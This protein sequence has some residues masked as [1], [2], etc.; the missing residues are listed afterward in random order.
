MI[1]KAFTMVAYPDKIEEYVKRHNPIWP[2]LEEVLKDHGVHNY[3]IFFDEDTCKLFGYVEVESEEKWNAIANTE[4]CQ[5]WW[6]YMDDLMV[7]NEDGSPTT[8]ELKQAF[9]LE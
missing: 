1:R 4:T 5:K 7:T 2:K 8:K 9:Y 6:S 3:S